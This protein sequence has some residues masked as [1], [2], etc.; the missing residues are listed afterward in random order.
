MTKNKSVILSILVLLV[1]STLNVN[2]MCVSGREYPS[3]F[4]DPAS[5]TGTEYTPGENFTILVKTDYNGT[6][7]WSYEFTLAYNPNVIQGVEV[8]NGDLITEAK[9]DSARFDLGTFNNT[10]GKLS[11]TVAYF[12]FTVRPV[13]LTYGP[14]ILA[15]VTFTIVGKGTSNI[16]LGPETVLKGVEE[17]GFGDRYDII[18]AGLDPAHIQHGYFAFRFQHDVAVVRVAT[19]AGAAVGSLVSIDV[20]VANLGEFD[21]VVNV[22][23]LYDSTLI[24]FNDTI[25]IPAQSNAIVPF[26]WN[27]TGLTYG[28]Y[29][30]NA[31]ATITG[32]GDLSDNWNTTTI[33]LAEHDVAVIGITAPVEV[34]VGSLVSIDVEVANLGEFD[35]VVNV[36]ILYDSTLIDFNDT[37]EIPAQSNAIVP[38]EWNTTGLTYGN[39]TLNA[40]ATITGDGDL[41]DNWNTTTILLAIHDLA[42]TRISVRPATIY[43]G[44]L[45]T[46]SVQVSNYGGFK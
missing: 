41:S 24:D 12:L 4:I 38:F 21:E 7:I 34:A 5:I 44:D 9:H 25:E 20:E 33:F 1:L 43:V 10:L 39:Y 19:D 46:I 31:T 14:G 11:L 42:V 23:I 16:T 26:E 22:T 28:N 37:I 30:L 17:D 35:E 18:D 45:A 2:T 8:T 40:T 15:N 32:D 6:D 36:T 29:T 27:T 13:P 3:I